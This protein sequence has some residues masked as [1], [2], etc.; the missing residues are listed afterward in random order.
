MKK[1]KLVP[2]V[3]ELKHDH[4]IKKNVLEVKQ[5]RDGSS[6]PV[7]EYQVNKEFWQ[8][9]TKPVSV[10]LDEAHSI[11]NARRAMSK[12]NVCVTDWLAL[13]RRVLGQSEAGYGELVFIT[14]LPNRIDIIAR[15]MATQVRYHICHFTKT[16]KR[17]GS[18]WKEHSEMPEPSW[19]CINCHSPQVKK[20]NHVIEV[21]HFSNM[22]SYMGWK[23]FG[24]QTYYRHYMINDIEDFFPLYDTMQWDNL[25]S[26]Y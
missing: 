16:C 26:E 6:E 2:H 23:E 8:K 13:I 21:W 14:Q 15:E 4:I 3:H 5:K 22:Q 19:S 9:Q 10:I 12:L 17:C 7:Y 20:H 1:K 24:M 25:I 18:S 11:V